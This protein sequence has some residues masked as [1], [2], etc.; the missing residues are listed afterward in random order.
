MLVESLRC[1]VG[2]R[3]GDADIMTRRAAVIA[4]LDGGRRRRSR[5]LRWRGQPRAS[6]AGRP[7]A[8][9]G[10]ATSASLATPAET[11]RVAWPQRTLVRRLRGRIIYV[12][13][14]R[15]VIDRATITC[16]GVG[17][18]QRSDHTLAWTGFHCVQL[19]FPADAVAGPD[20]VFDVHPTGPRSLRV[21]AARLR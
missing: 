1:I 8:T 3:A 21:A 10:G 12:E 15:V 18:A 6:T 19:T 20:A 14:R 9:T 4:A 5:R 13:G 2:A 17:R 16:Q 7:V 11:G